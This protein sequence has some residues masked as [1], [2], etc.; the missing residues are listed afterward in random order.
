MTRSP[1]SPA[2]I[3]SRGRIAKITTIVLTGQTRYFAARS[4]RHQIG[5]TCGSYLSAGGT[6][7]P[8]GK[9]L[10]ASRVIVSSNATPGSRGRSVGSFGGIFKAM[11]L[12][13][14]VAG[15]VTKVAGD[16]I[17]V[18]PFASRQG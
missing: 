11:G 5:H 7:S 17:T 8:N 9:T 2:S 1:S 18:Q 4:H 3:R 15:T 14:P 13:T 12:G 16:T 6:A 10:T